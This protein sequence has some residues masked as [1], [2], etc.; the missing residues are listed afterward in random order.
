VQQVSQND[1]KVLQNVIIPRQKGCAKIETLENIVAQISK[2]GASGGLSF[3][4][5]KKK[6]KK[7]WPKC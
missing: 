3:Q 2:L 1:E 7:W 6:I 5:L 4:N